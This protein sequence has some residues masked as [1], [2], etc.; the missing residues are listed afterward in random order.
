MCCLFSLRIPNYLLEL[1]SILHSDYVFHPK[2]SIPRPDSVLDP[3]FYYII[4][5]FKAFL[6]GCHS[7]FYF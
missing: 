6:S 4:S 3:E 5:V 7:S 2:L 1:K